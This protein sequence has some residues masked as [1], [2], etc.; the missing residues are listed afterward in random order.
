MR[1]D[2][3]VELIVFIMSAIILALSLLVSWEFILILVITYITL[4]VIEYEESR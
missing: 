2:I 4:F 1:K 3:I